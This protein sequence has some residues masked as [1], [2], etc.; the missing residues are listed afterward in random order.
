[1]RVGSLGCCNP[2]IGGSGHRYSPDLAWARGYLSSTVCAHSRM[3]PGMRQPELQ[4][5]HANKPAARNCTLD[6]ECR[7]S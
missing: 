7:Y 2:S 3:A 1:M 4:A 5:A 6:S